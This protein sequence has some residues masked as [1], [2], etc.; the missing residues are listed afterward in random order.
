MQSVIDAAE[1]AARLKISRAQLLRLI[2]ER[3]IPPP[4]K[5]FGWPVREFSKIGC[6][7]NVDT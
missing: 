1:A 2:L 3:K 6:E 5:I 4:K 7:L